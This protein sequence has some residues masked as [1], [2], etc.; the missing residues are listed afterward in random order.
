[1][2]HAQRLSTSFALSKSFF[3]NFTYLGVRAVLVLGSLAVPIS[4]E[5]GKR[6]SALRLR[7]TKPADTSSLRVCRR[8]S[9]GTDAVSSVSQDNIKRRTHMLGGFL[10]GAITGGLVVWKY[11]DYL[12]QYVKGNAEPAREKVDGLLRTLQQ[13]SETLLD[14]A[15]E[16]LSSRLESTREKVRTGAPEAGRER[17]TE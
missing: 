2:W 13:K 9:G 10:V 4:E 8:P 17:P 14:Q 6:C 12:S 1:M 7:G 15:K 5:R 16:Q 11:R 3:D